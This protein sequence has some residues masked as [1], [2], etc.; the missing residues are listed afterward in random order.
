MKNKK[1]VRTV[2]M[3][4]GI[5]LL[6]GP[7]FSIIGY[8]TFR[9]WLT[10]FSIIAGII[11]IVLQAVIGFLMVKSILFHNKN[12]AAP[13]N[14]NKKI[15]KLLVG[16]FLLIGPLLLIYVL[17]TDSGISIILPSMIIGILL[18]AII[19]ILLLKNP[20]SYKNHKVEGYKIQ[21]KRRKNRKI[22]L[23]LSVLGF[24]LILQMYASYITYQA[25]Q[26]VDNKN[27][28]FS[29]L[30]IKNRF[31]VNVGYG[32]NKKISDN[33]KKLE[34]IYFYECFFILKNW[35]YNLFT[36]LH[37]NHISLTINYDHSI[38]RFLWSI[39]EGKFVEWQ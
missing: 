17:I 35:Y 23:L 13:P 25:Y 16:Q 21:S 39:R 34:S 8:L 6:L 24:I 30:V 33:G 38:K 20:I 1:L 14:K 3:I 19:G 11:G 7:L 9:K 10:L 5:M 4:L 12:Q 15:L 31:S 29:E 37:A 27:G 26:L 2:K 22:R 32:I 28:Y 36:E 18:E